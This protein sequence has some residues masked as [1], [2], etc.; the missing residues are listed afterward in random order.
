[1][2]PAVGEPNPEPLRVEVTGLPAAGPSSGDLAR[3]LR[4]LGDRLAANLD[5]GREH[6]QRSSEHLTA[7][8]WKEAL[9]E[10]ATALARAGADAAAWVLRGRAR[11]GLRQYDLAA[12]DL[13]RALALAPEDAE[14]SHHRA[15]CHDSL[16]RYREAVADFTAALKESPADAHL[17]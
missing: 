10:A 12:C 13:T 9:E 7:E 14:A 15:H 8:R 17:L 11:Y 5:P 6:R 4:A 3:G 16:G 1:P 2:Y